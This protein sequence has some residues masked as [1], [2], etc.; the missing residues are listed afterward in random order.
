MRL[1]QARLDQVLD[2]FREI[3][4]RMGAASDGG[5]IVRLS[6]EHAELRPVAEAVLALQKAEAE[7]PE[8]AAMAADPDPDISELARDEL[9]RL[10]ARLPEMERQ[11]ALLLAPRDKDENASAILEV[12]AGTGGDEAALFAGDLF[13]MYSRYA[14]S[15]GWRVE[16]DS[17]SE[18]EMGGY[19]EIIASI[20]GEGVFGRLKFESGVHRVQRV[21]ETEAQGR[22]HT[23]AATV[24]VLPEAED[25]DIV[26]NDADLRIDT[27]RSSGAGGQHVN[28][29]DSAVRITHLPTGIVATSSE[30]SQHE[31]RRKA[32]A[33]LKARLY[34]LQRQALDA[35]RADARKSQVGSG[36]RSE[37]IRTY[38]F[39]QGR[40]T[41]HRINLTL[42]NLPKV[43]E[44]E[45]LDDVID[46]LIAEDQAAR[47]ASLE[48]SFG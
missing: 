32:M 36:D 14:A 20:T 4:A 37:R 39:P 44:G 2:R 23:S 26:I 3:E 38:N 30:K 43:M 42:Y 17:V 34:D 13:R 35:A 47:L 16:I 1:P 15:R 41:D 25:V 22:I 7:K 10:E 40:V 6:K 28:K 5:E 29:T 18:G 24:A 8:L 46:P 21:P 48:E 19:K 45:A 33:N 9:E 27:Y 12:R 31:N 11:V